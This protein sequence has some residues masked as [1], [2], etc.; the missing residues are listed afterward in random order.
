M[1]SWYVCTRPGT[2][3]LPPNHRLWETTA[4]PHHLC[5]CYSRCEKV[6][7]APSSSACHSIR[8]SHSACAWLHRARRGQDT[9]GGSGQANWNPAMCCD[10]LRMLWNYLPASKLFL[11]GI[12]TCRQYGWLWTRTPARNSVQ[13][14]KHTL[15]V[16]IT[17]VSVKR[18]RVILHFS[19]V[20]WYI[21]V[22]RNLAT[23]HRDIINKIIWESTA[24]PIYGFFAVNIAVFSLSWMKFCEQNLCWKEFQ[25]LFH[26]WCTVPVHMFLSELWNGENGMWDSCDEVNS[27]LAFS[28]WSVKRE[29]RSIVNSQSP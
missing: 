23:K 8:H 15:S 29:V 27:K 10:H 25:L 20:R 1:V 14:H 3:S 17:T 18:T 7:A 11:A 21:S 13:Q 16:P 24:I 28:Y 4:H 2:D 26:Q 19:G 6:R 5:C 12:S 22:V 9:L